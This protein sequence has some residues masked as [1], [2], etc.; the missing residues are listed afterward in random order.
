MFAKLLTC[1]C[2]LHPRFIH[3]VLRPQ[4]ES[5]ACCFLC[6]G[7]FVFDAFENG[8]LKFRAYHATSIVYVVLFL[9][10]AM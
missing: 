7:A 3:A 1:F 5:V 9:D 6:I 10:S 2:E 4:S 8:V